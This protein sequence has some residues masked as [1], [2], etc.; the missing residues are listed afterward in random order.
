MVIYDSQI[1]FRVEKVN[2]VPNAIHLYV[3]GKF[4]PSDIPETLSLNSQ[5]FQGMFE[6]ERFFQLVQP[7][8]SSFIPATAELFSKFKEE[9]RDLAVFLHLEIK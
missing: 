6:F 9:F 2:G 8:F 1:E 4:S 5:E 3:E 7:G